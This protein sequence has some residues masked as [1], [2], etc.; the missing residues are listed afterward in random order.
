MLFSEGA[1]LLAGT[2]VTNAVGESALAGKLRPPRKWSYGKLL[3]AGGA[4]ALSAL[5]VLIHLVMA[6]SFPVPSSGIKLGLLIGLG[7]FVLLVLATWRHN[8]FAYPA[9]YDQWDRSYLCLR[10]AAVTERE[11]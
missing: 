11:F 1:S 10:C 8:R 4:V 6:S 7:L 3:L 5:V 2:A 9:L